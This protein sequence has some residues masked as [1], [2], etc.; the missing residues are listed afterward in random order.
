MN[1]PARASGIAATSAARSPGPLADVLGAFRREAQETVGCLPAPT[2]SV[3]YGAA[4][5]AFA[6]TRLGTM[7]DDD[8]ALDTAERWLSWPRN[9][10]A[11]PTHSTTAT[12]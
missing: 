9:I 4:G 1:A 12:S 7:A 2:C 3:N 11:I 6:L 10:R 5:V 8:E